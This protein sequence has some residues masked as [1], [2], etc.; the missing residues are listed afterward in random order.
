M[1]KVLVEYVRLDRAGERERESSVLLG[2]AGEPETLSEIGDTAVLTAGAPA[3]GKEGGLIVPSG[4]ARITVLLGAVQCSWGG[5]APDP[6]KGVRIVAGG[7]EILVQLKQGEKLGFIEAPAEQEVGG[8]RADLQAAGNAA[9]NDLA[10]AAAGPGLKILPPTLRPAEVEPITSTFAASG[11]SAPFA[12]ELGRPINVSLTPA[13]DAWDGSV[14]LLRKLPDAEHYQPLTMLG[15]PWAV[16][17][18]AISEPVWEETEAGCTFV[19]EC[20]HVAGSIA[21]RISQ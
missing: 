15:E 3:W 2:L 5:T 17:T 8:A 7:R 13:D 14:R 10:T 4:Y 21:Y 20:D 16:F 18:G 6:T 12:A 11:Q 9:L 19:L 1:A